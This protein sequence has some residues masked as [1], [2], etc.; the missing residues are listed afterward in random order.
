MPVQSRSSILLVSRS[1]S[2]FPLREPTGIGHRNLIPVPISSTTKASSLESSTR[3]SGNVSWILKIPGRT[4]AAVNLE[5]IHSAG[6][7][8]RQQ[9][10]AFCFPFYAANGNSRK[11][12][13]S[14]LRTTLSRRTT[15]NNKSQTSKEKDVARGSHIYD[16]TPMISQNNRKKSSSDFHE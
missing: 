1:C 7:K 16:Q 5:I 9:L 8:F 10:T 13:K 3:I 6:R 14:T 12:F 11:T 15:E 2:V 4:R